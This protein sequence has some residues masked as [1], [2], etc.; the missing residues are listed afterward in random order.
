MANVTIT[1]NRP[2]AAAGPALNHFSGGRLPLRES[3]NRPVRKG[4]LPGGS[5]DWSTVFEAAELSSCAHFRPIVNI[6]LFVQQFV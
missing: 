1:D 5:I 3:Y 4:R 2:S 6:F